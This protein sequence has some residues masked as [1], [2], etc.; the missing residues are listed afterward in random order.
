MLE[1]DAVIKCK[2]IIELNLFIERYLA[3]RNIDIPSEEA[4]RYYWA[5]FYR[6]K[7]SLKMLDET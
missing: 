7:S 3:E 4:S 6:W 5:L 2:D 1:F